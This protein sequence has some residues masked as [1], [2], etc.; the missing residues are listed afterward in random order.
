HLNTIDSLRSAGRY[1]EALE[2]CR[3]TQEKFNNVTGTTALFDEA[4][5]YLVKGDYAQALDAFTRLRSRNLSQRAPGATNRMEVEF[6]RAYCFEKI[7]RISEA[8]DAYFAFPV[9][10][11]SY[12]GN[13]A[14]LRLSALAHDS[15]YKDLISGR[16]KF[17]LDD[18]RKEIASGDYHGAKASANQAL[19]IVNDSKA[20]S[21]LLDILRR[22][23]ANL[24]EYNQ[25][26]N[27]AL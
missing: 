8:V 6:M 5:I 4:K 10:R 19:R 1:D 27:F 16:F 11:N 23:Y 14:T 26:S 9:D 12:Y 17:F 20:E 3:K 7:G 21:E 15:K 22:C 2:W 18:A 25:F 24:P 13:R